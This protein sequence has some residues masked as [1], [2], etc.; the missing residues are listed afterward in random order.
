MTHTI[1]MGVDGIVRTTFFDEI[2][3]ISVE[4]F[5]NDISPFIIASSP[6]FPLNLIF[7][8]SKATK[9]TSKSRKLLIEFLKDN[10]IGEVIIINARKEIEVF[11]K[12]SNKVIF[13]KNIEFLH[14]EEKNIPSS[15]E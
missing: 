14:S 15:I 2:D 9:T 6:D 3:E 8:L 4:F 7:E 11:F 1:D 12:L 10:R 13:D 5:L